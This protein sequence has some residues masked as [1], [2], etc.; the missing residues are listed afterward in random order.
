MANKKLKN[1]TL[2]TWRLPQ[3]P[4]GLLSAQRFRRANKRIKLKNVI[5]YL[6][7][8]DGYTLHKPAR[9]RFRRRRV[10]VSGPFDQWIGDLADMQKYAAYNDDMKYILFYIDAATRKLYG[11][12]TPSKSATSVLQATKV[13]FQ[14]SK[15]NPRA[16]QFDKGGEFINNTLKSFLKRSKI[17]MFTT[18]DEITKGS[19]VERVILT[20]KRMIHT[21]FTEHH[22]RRYVDVLQKFINAYNNSFHSS[23]G[24]APNDVNQDNYV[25]AMYFRERAPQFNGKP[26]FSIGDYVRLL[27]KKATF[28]RGF[29]IHWTEQVYKIHSILRTTPLTYRV[30]D[31]KGEVIEGSFYKQEL[32]KIDWPSRFL[33]EKVLN[34]RVRKENNKK[35]CE[36]YV[37]YLGY[38]SKFDEWIK[39]SKVKD[40]LIPQQ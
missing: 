39:E 20:M 1:K 21:Y 14:R 4:G 7:G 31:L 22:T 25:E 8:L 15:R 3:T 37:R 17:H 35:I 23:I 24:M 27:G 10:V 5:A 28:D 19:Q 34:T 26:K 32:I 6:R 33:I 36:A 38:P 9:R 12:A 13:I 11:E 29:D 2:K 18:E 30:E 40:L 16:I